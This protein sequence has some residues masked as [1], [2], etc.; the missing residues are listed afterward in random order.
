[1]TGKIIKGIA[2]FYYVNNGENKV[3]QCKAKGIFRNRKIKPLV[4]DDVE[5]S[6]LDEEAMEGNID[7]I[8]P[9]KNELIRPAAANVD[10]A[11]VLF[12]LTHPAPNLNL[13]DRFLVMMSMEDIPV[14][15]CFN[16]QDLGDEALMDQYRSIYEAA[17]YP[18]Y[19][20]SAREETGIEQVRS[21]LRGKT[22]VLAGPSGV[23]KSSLTNRI[24]P[25]ADM[26][27]GDISRKIERGK[28][29]TRHSQLF[30]VEKDEEK[31]VRQIIILLTVAAVL[32]ISVFTNDLHQLVFRFSKQPPFSDRDYSY[33]ILFAVIQGW[34]LSCLTGME[35]I[36]IRKS[37][38]P[39]KKQFWLPVI[40]GILL[41]GWNVGNIFHLSFI[42]TLAGDMTAVC[43]LLMAAIY[44]GCIVCGLIQTNNRYFE[45]FQTSGGLD[46]EITDDSFH[47]YYHSGDFPKLSP[48]MRTMIIHRSSVQEQGIRI[49]HIPIRGGHLFWSED[50]SIL[51]DQYQDIREQQEEL[52]AR[53][54]LL[55]KTYEKEAERRKTEEQ[56]S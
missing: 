15:L 38:I 52:T 34:M 43:C 14:K 25:E 32:I 29:T 20:I 56:N 37:R 23:G 1:M 33:G 18:V 30:F 49:N 44:Q 16:K 36:L 21:L 31:T 2:G 47:R 10:Q 4:G 39:G 50:I 45:L 54:R 28:H 5:F 26:E 35:I 51:L 42:K 7:E 27:T 6:V 13:L 24:Q 55:Q 9:R 48:E 17:G 8:L 46:A 12:A 19:F 22:T 11:L 3:Y 41:L 40:P 53:N